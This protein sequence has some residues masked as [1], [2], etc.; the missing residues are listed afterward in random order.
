MGPSEVL[1]LRLASLG[2]PVGDFSAACAQVA[3]RHYG[4]PAADALMIRAAHKRGMQHHVWTI[5]DDTEME[6]LI[7]LGV[8]GI[9]TDQPARLKAVLQR[10]GL[11]GT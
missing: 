2:V 8:D 11:W 6:R 5:D 9:M 3:C 7:D 10:R 1:R 4:I